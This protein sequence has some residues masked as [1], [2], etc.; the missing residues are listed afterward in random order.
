LNYAEGGGGDRP[1]VVIHG[2]TMRWQHM[3]V[4]FADLADTAHIYACDLR[5]HGRSDWADSGYRV[6][7]YVDDVVAFVRAVSKAGSVLVGY[8]LGGLV[9]FGVAARLPDLVAGVVAIDPVLM[10]R[11]CDFEALPS[12]VHDWVRWVHDVAGGALTPSEAVAQF[13]TMY[14]GTGEQQAHEALADVASVDPRVTAAFLENRLYEGFDIEQNLDQVAC[15]ALLLAAEVELGSLV[16]DKD[17]DLVLAHTA[18]ARAKRIPG[19]G[20]DIM[21]LA[22]PARTVHTDVGDFIDGL[23]RRRLTSAWSKLFRS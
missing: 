15:P 3:E 9:A 4:V 21:T 11:D 17:L 18:H 13:T 7:D 2:A 10:T 19:A 23:H 5:G 12:R 6:G 22:E 16:R 1:V 8:S 20:H 14:P